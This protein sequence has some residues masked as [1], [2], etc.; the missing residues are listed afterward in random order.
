MI[1][2][3]RHVLRERITDVQHSGQVCRFE[4]NK[5]RS[6]PL[7]T[8]ARTA[9]AGYVAPLL[10]VEPT[11]KAVACAWSSHPN[12]PLWISQKGGRLSVS[13]MG[14]MFDELVRRC[15]GLP[16]EVSA[17]WLRHTFATRYLATH[18]GDLVGL[19]R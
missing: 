11:L 6:I 18:P 10:Q 3:F 9:L 19:A 12:D 15:P 4:G 16:E 8:S 2:R 14:R 1:R 17:H 5:A 7:N 13:A